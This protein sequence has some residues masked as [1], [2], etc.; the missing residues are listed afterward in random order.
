[1]SKWILVILTT[2]LLLPLQAVAFD[3]DRLQINGFISQGYLD[4]SKNNFLTPDSTKGTTEFNEIGITVSS[5]ISDKLRAGVHLLSRDLG[6]VGNNEVRLDWGFADYRYADSLGL[7]F[8]K[9]KLPMGLYGEGRDADMLRPMVFL[10]QSI[11]EE[12]KRDLLV[13]Y[14]GAGLYGNLPFGAL[15]DL[16]YHGFY[17]SINFDKDSQLSRAVE[18][19]LTGFLKMK[20]SYEVS[21]Y[22]IDNDYTAGGSLVMNT[23]LDGLRMGISWL[24]VR[25]KVLFSAKDASGTTVAGEGTLDN[26]GQFVASLEYLAGDLTLASEYSEHS[27]KK[28]F[29]GLL[30]EDSTSQGWYVLAAYSLLDHLTLSV[31]YDEYYADKDDKDGKILSQKPGQKDFFAW[32]KDIGIGARYDITQ[33]WLVKAEYHDVNGAAQF[34]TTVNNP[35]DLVEDWNYFVVKTTVSF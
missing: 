16:D 3:V 31:L 25:N 9:V 1:M 12:G 7:R 19:G 26:K 30:A 24:T 2:L 34:M 17:G 15:G 11:Y 27:G 33:N 35:A 29:D 28:I 10:P 5:Q 22:E 13:A 18:A 14:Q 20:R 4:S 21:D 23:A 6:E 32:R 8:G